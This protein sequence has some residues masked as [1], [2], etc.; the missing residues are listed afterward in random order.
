MPLDKLNS[1]QFLHFALAEFEQFGDQ[2]GILFHKVPFELRYSIKR[3]IA[4]PERSDHVFQD[5]QGRHVIDREGWEQYVSWV[6]K[7]L[8]EAVA[9]C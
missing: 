7:T 4:R 5:D 1:L 6:R 9:Q 8:D 2:E 3:W